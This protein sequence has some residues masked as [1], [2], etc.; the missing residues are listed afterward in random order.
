MEGTCDTPC[1][2]YVTGQLVPTAITLYPHWHSFTHYIT[3]K[4]HVV[5][6]VWALTDVGRAAVSSLSLY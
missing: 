4:L 2:D 1:F 3:A 6:F 5:P